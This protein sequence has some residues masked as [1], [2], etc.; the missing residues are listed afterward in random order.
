MQ[1]AFHKFYAFRDFKFGRYVENCSLGSK[2]LC[3][4]GLPPHTKFNNGL[5]RYMKTII[6]AWVVW[7]VRCGGWSSAAGYTYFIT[8]FFTTFIHISKWD[9]RDLYLLWMLLF[10]MLLLSYTFKILPVFLHNSNLCKWK[11]YVCLARASHFFHL[12]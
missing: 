8:T 5:I 10:S 6:F 1:F 4:E 2:I 12:A 9:I 3:I 11:T 7:S